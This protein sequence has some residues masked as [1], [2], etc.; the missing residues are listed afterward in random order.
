MIRRLL[1]GREA[2]WLLLAGA[3]LPLAP[4][5]RH[6]RRGAPIAW[7]DAWR[8]VLAST[9]V[10]RPTPMCISASSGRCGCRARCWLR[11]PAPDWRWRAPCYG[12]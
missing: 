10:R 9:A 1:P 5:G 11:W 3:A 8:I 12:R 2:G 7:H 6:P 4:A